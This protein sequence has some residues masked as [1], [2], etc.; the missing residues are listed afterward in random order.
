VSNIG[1]FHPFLIATRQTAA[2]TQ[3]TTSGPIISSLGLADGPLRWRGSIGLEWQRGAFTAAWNMQ[4]YD[5]YSICT[6][7]NSPAQCDTTIANQGNA[8]VPDQSYHD[9]LLR[10][11]SPADRGF[12]AGL[13]IAIGVQNIFDARPPVIA[14]PSAIT[15]T[16][17]GYGDPRLRR[18]T[19]SIRKHFGL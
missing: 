7:G 13:D 9:L 14:Q 11:S 2:R 1:S 18:F 10:Y 3:L 15:M 8:R 4:Y 5:S 17:S 19:L 16:Y 12:L 6:S